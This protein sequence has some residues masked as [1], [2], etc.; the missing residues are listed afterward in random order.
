M[1]QRM[2]AHPA[3]RVIARDGEWLRDAGAEDVCFSVDVET[4]GPIPGLYSMLSFAFVVAGR[5]DGVR[6]AA[7]ASYDDSFYRELTPISETYE[8]AAL[9]VNGLDRERLLCEGGDPAQVMSEA[10][11]WVRVRAG[12]ATPVLVA[13][14]L[15]FDWS[16]L[17]WYFVRFSRTGSPFNHSRCYDLKTA[18]AVKGELPIAVAGREQLPPELRSTRAHTH[19]ALDDAIEQAEIFSKLFTWGKSN[20]GDRE[21]N[22]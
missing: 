19:N 20:E 12:T 14:P 15:S 6:F 7:P 21:T 9:A 17:Y 13:Y 10:A 22:R 4:D 5:F 8:P 3:A 18:F 1:P 11:E 16:W 2:S